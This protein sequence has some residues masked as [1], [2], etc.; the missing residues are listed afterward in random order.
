MC[1]VSAPF[2]YAQDLALS[3]LVAKC[4]LRD[5]ILTFA[6]TH[7]NTPLLASLLYLLGVDFAGLVWGEGFELVY[8]IFRIIKPDNTPYNLRL[9]SCQLWK[10]VKV[11]R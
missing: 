10:R 9:G 5:V 6:L 8:E 3:F 1:G 7:P 2:F 11:A 4:E